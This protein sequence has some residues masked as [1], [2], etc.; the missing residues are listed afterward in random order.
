MSL[1][2]TDLRSS[3]VEV[4]RLQGELE[5]TRQQSQLQA[6]ELEALREDAREALVEQEALRQELAR[7][8]HEV[9]GR[10]PLLDDPTELSRAQN[11]LVQSEAMAAKLSA[12]VLQLRAQLLPRSEAPSPKSVDESQL[13]D[14]LF[15]VKLLGLCPVKT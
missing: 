13:Q 10:I 12:E 4:K 2:A 11:A 1:M 9:Q 3:L 14:E 5:K 15:E 8:R 7:V 6:E